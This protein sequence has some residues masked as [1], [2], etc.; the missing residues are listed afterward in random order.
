MST[1]GSTRRTRGRRRRSRAFALAFAAS[2]GVL[3]LVGAAGA[4]IGIAQG[5]RV[6]DVQVDPAA[7][8]SASGSRVI[9]TT[10]Q[11]LREV[12]AAQVTVE[13]AAPFTV[14]TSGRNVGVRF[15]LPLRD[16]TDYT[17]T[18]DDAAGQGAGP[19]ATLSASFRTPS[20]QPYLLQRGTDGDAIFRTDL[21]GRN[22]EPVFEHPHIEDYRATASHLV[23]SVRTDDDRAA[24]LVAGPN[25][26]D[27]RELEL[28]GDGFVSNLQSADRGET[29]GFTF[30]D[31]DLGVG[32]GLESALFTVSVADG[33]TAPPAQVALVGDDS[34]V[35]QWRFV[36]DTDSILVLTFDG[37]LL[38]SGADGEDAAPLGSALS[39]DGIARGSSLAVVERFEGMR[40][41]DLTD[42]SEQP[43]VEPVG[44]G[45]L[46]SLNAVTPRPGEAAGTVRTYA[47][48]T[49]DGRFASTVVA[50]VAADGAATVLLDAAETDAVLQTCVSAS[51]RYAAITVAPDAASNPYDR[52]ELPLPERVETRVVE[53]ASGAEVVALDGVALSWCQGPPA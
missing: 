19:A 30:A 12:D 15:A 33:A 3:A 53:V 13:P 17:V 37:R 29:I 8:V 48:L 35:A 25:G 1:D 41:V 16:D 31:A 43:L 24:V 7:A 23:V 2:L 42:G 47:V 6:T 39:I 11:A 14:D 32:G 5:P 4:A 46:G 9:L 18:I 45:E 26:E 22:A 51:G 27:P 34:R 44:L 49:T 50:H 36:P 52:Y 28:P 40:V 38:L 20:L 10:T 21:T